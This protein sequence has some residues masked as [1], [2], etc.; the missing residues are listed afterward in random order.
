MDQNKTAGELAAKAVSDPSNYDALEVG[1]ALTADIFENLVE[2][3]ERHNKIFDE[4]EY[5]IVLLIVDDPLLGRNLRRRK[6]YGF[7]YL[8][9]PRPAQTVFLYNKRKDSFKRLWCI[10]DAMTMAIISDMTT[11]SQKYKDLKRWTDYFYHGWVSDPILGNYIN[12]TPTYFFEQIRKEHDI[13]MLSE[14]E[15]LDANREK[16]IKA[17]CK[18][19]D[20]FVAEA[21]DFGKIAPKEVADPLVPGID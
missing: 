12:T 6:F 5:C 3:A 7:P 19:T 18:E 4:D 1:H 14:K 9:K 13:K 20:T 2:C 10:P 17:G 11:V 8:P 21:F 15:Y 16:L